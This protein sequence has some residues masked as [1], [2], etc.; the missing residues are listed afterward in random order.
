MTLLLRLLLICMPCTGPFAPPLVHGHAHND[1]WHA[2]PLQDALDHGFYSVEA[3]VH[4]LQGELRVG[5]SPEEAT[6]DRTL[7]KLYL[8]PL[9]KRASLTNQPHVT[10]LIDVKSESGATYA[11]LR[12]L[13]SNYQEILTSFHDDKV[14]VCAITVILT[15][16]YPRKTIFAEKTRWVACDGGLE[17]LDCYDAAVGRSS[18]TGPG[19]L[20]RPFQVAWRRSDPAGR[21]PAIAEVRRD[22]A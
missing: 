8:D 9:K 14:E 16:G 4:L 5:H 22:G 6:A 7:K 18:P 13:L 1:Y 3:D 12:E 19:Q 21:A 15:G 20:A 11:A 2:R 17:D 10:L